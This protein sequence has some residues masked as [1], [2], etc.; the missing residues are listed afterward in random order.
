MI[1]IIDGITNANISKSRYLFINTD[2]GDEIGVDLERFCILSPKIKDD[3]PI[4]KETIV[5]IF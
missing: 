4:R 3:V 1:R 2:V 5:R